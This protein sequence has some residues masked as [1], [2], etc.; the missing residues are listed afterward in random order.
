MHL[1]CKGYLTYDELVGIT[2]YSYNIIVH[3]S[4]GKCLINLRQMSVYPEGAVNYLRNTWYPKIAAAG[5]NYVAIV[6]P[7]DLFGKISMQVTHEGEN[8]HKLKKSYFT[9]EES[10]KAWLNECM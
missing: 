2:E 6:E 5:I 3:H 9:D 7:E 10:A 4:L 1:T 8:V